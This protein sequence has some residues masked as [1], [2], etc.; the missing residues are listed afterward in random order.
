MDF[1]LLDIFFQVIVFLFAISVHES[2]HAWMANQCGDPTAKMLG[3]ITLNPIKHM[4]PFGTLLLPAI[5]LYTGAGLFGWAKPCPVTP[6]NFREPVK[7]DILTTLAGPVSNFLMVV[8]SVMGLVL[9]SA[10]TAQG[11]QLVRNLATGRI[12]NTGSS[13]MPII[14]LLYTAVYLNVLLGIFNLIPVPPLD[15]SHVFRHLLPTALRNLYDKAGMIGL[16]LLFTVGR[17]LVSA[18]VTPALLLVNTL[19]LRI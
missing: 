11:H 8:I 14:W 5:G 6:Q 2:A 15:G 7:G 18:V 19:L 1:K 3:R 12:T 10:S 4:D 16:L 17:P 13:L 9:I